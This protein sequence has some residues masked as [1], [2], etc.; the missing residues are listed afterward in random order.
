[1]S[2]GVV[3]SHLPSL[4]ATLANVNDKIRRALR[5]SLSLSKECLSQNS[6][7]HYTHVYA[8]FGADLYAQL[9]LIYKISASEL[10]PRSTKSKS[11]LLVG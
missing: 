8:R 11:A 7:R 6:I 4:C 9:V 10:S 5:S 3:A 1:M 2:P